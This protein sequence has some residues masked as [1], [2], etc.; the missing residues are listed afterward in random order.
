MIV[1]G[2]NG[3]SALAHTGPSGHRGSKSTTLIT[4]KQ[5]YWSAATT[6][7]QT[8]VKFCIHYLSKTGAE[9]IRQPYGPAFN[10]TPATDLLQ[11]GYIEIAPRNTGEK[12]ISML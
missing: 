6:D 12:Y 9:R 1:L 2:C 11:F 10:G 3:N 4:C 5:C 7:I 8:F